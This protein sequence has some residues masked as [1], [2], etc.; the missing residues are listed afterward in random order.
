M[1]EK[2]TVNIYDKKFSLCLED[3]FVNK[4]NLFHIKEV[5]QRAENG[6]RITIA[7]IGGSITQG[8]LSEWYSNCYS[9]LVFKWFEEKFPKTA[10]TYVNAGVGGTTSHFGVARV[11]QDVLR[12]HPDLVFVEFSVNDENTDFFQETYEGLIRRIISYP[13]NP[14]VVLLHNDF[15]DDRESAEDIHRRIGSHY[16]L[17]SISIGSSIIPEVQSKAIMARELTSDDLHPNTVGHAL[18]AKVIT[19][20]LEQ[21]YS[22]LKQKEAKPEISSPM[23]ANAYENAKR[24]QYGTY[25]PECEGFVQDTSPQKYVT[26]IFH[27]GYTADKK[28]DSI[29]FDIYG[30]EF[31]VQYRKTINKPA[32]IAIAILDG[33]EENATILDANFE[34]TWGDCLFLQSIAHHIEKKKHHIEIRIIETHEDDRVPFYLVSVIG[35]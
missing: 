30:S 13:L 2:T 10:F 3:A 5:M 1:S 18:L 8:C 22:D 26:D 17:P 29:H 31:A 7:F 19:H 27:Y 21:I 28:G 4:G 6:D 12:H 9:Y 32:P 34:E 25:E 35:A 15:Y 14:A 23:T 24:Y 20:C 33:D 16:S 11:E